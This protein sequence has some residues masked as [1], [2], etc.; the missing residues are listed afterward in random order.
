MFTLFATLISSNWKLNFALFFWMLFSSYLSAIPL[1]GR[2]AG[3]FSGFVL[4]LFMAAILR[5]INRS[6]S[7]EDIKRELVQ[8]DLFE[9]MS[10]ANKEAVLGA[11][12]G[13]LIN[14]LI[15]VISSIFFLSLLILPVATLAVLN[16][17][18]WKALMGTGKST[19]YIIG[20]ILLTLYI[21]FNFLFTASVAMAKGFLKSSFWEGFVEALKGL[22]PKYFLLSLKPGLWKPSMLLTIIAVASVGVSA[23]IALFLGIVG[24]PILGVFWA[25]MGVILFYANIAYHYTC[26]KIMGLL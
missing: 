2:L 20:I 18:Q 26:L 3:L 6:S 4:S 5:I 25:T 24:L 9:I 11:Y 10:E 17:G 19:L 15:I 13:M 21:A 1:F 14:T 8:K 12:L 16:P 22:T 23:M 7:L